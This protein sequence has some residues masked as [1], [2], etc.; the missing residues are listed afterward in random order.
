V[1]NVPCIYV[2]AGCEKQ[3]DDG[4]RS[5]EVE[6]H[7]SIS[8]T[9]MHARWIVGD[10]PSEEVG[11]IEVRRGASIR[12]GASRNQS[13]RDVTSRRVERVK[14][15]RPPIAAPIRVGAEV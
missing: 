6:W 15:A 7:L 4:A 14:S 10:H 2:R 8:P 9:F 3:V 11:T 13:V 12:D 5:C 1:V